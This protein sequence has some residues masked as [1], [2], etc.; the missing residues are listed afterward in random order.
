MKLVKTIAVA[1]FFII[2]I[3]FAL[4][5]QQLVALHYYDLIPVFSVPLFLLVFFSILLGILIAGFG[6][7][8]VRY[9][10][11]ARSRRCERELKHLKEQMASIRQE[12]EK[13]KESE[14]SKGTKPS[15]PL[16]I[17]PSKDA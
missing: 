17:A 2:A 16:Q 9:S 5:N 14:E 7:I 13:M 15:T 4:Q 1:V 6:D 12:T 3:T 10:L 8:F 11:S